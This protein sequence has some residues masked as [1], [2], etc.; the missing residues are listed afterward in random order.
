MHS[1]EPQFFGKSFSITFF[2]KDKVST[3]TDATRLKRGASAKCWVPARRT[4]L[5][6]QAGAQRS[7]APL[8]N[9]FVGY[10]KNV[11]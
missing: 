1:E 9:V 5:A 4:L 2:T 10:R 11:G 7:G 3:Y 6:P 8:K